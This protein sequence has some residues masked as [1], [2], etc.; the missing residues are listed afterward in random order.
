[1][2]LQ[3]NNIEKKRLEKKPN[4]R[5]LPFEIKGRR[6]GFKI[7]FV[8][9]V[10]R[11]FGG[12]IKEIS[13]ELEHMFEKGDLCEKIVAETH[14]SH[15]HLTTPIF[16]LVFFF[17]QGFLSRTFMIHRTAGEGGAGRGG[18]RRG[19]LFNSSLLLPPA[20]QQITAESSP[21]HIASSRTRTGNLWF[22]SAI[23]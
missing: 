19:Y 22:P 10:I 2:F 11:A 4:Y 14:K 23:C 21:L 12:G 7:K 17:Y 5:Q 1:M 9:L 8:P 13:K 16:C 18:G 3:E 20:L 6:P 15:S